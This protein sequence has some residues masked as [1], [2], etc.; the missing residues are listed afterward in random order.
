MRGS[1]VISGYKQYQEKGEVWVVVGER[2]LL[3]YQTFH[4]TSLQHISKLLPL[5]AH[6]HQI[7]SLKKILVS[8][9][10]VQ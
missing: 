5:L 1:K 4:S 2:D 10:K 3:V 6:A 9:M 8:K 7:D